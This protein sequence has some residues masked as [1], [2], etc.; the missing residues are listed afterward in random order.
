CNISQTR[1]AGAIVQHRCE[2]CLLGVFAHDIPQRL[3]PT[4]GGHFTSVGTPFWTLFVLLLLADL[5]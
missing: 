5:R 1:L 4:F 3:C 2:F